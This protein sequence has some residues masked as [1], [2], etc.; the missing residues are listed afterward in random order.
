MSRYA[1]DAPEHIRLERIA[2]DLGAKVVVGPLDGGLARLLRRGDRG[3]IRISDSITNDGRRRFS[4]GHELGHFVLRHEGGAPRGCT[5]RDLVDFGGSAYQEMQANVFATEFLL[6]RKLVAKRCDV[7]KASL[8][9]VRKI[10]E[11]FGTS[12]TSAALRFVE[13]T[14]EPCA[15]VFSVDGE[16]A[17]FRKNSAFFGF[18]PARGAEISGW[19]MAGRYFSSGLEPANYAQWVDSDAWCEGK[20]GM[21]K[22]H[23][24]PI[25]S[26]GA[27]LSLL[28]QAPEE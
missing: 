14:A 10:A 8:R 13:L 23:T 2:K 24:M 25:P 26:I 6:P 15:V 9:P 20:G 16:V 12:V 3:V 17:W 18:L 27:A 28:W 22:E 4:I 21:L 7:S 19:S 11:D 1:I 5:D